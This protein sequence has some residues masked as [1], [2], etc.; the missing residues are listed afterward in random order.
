MKIERIKKDGG[1][2]GTCTQ[3]GDMNFEEV[4]QFVYLGELI[5]SKCEEEKEI[6]A[7]LSKAN[8]IDESMSHPLGTKQLSRTTKFRLYE[9]VIRPSELY[10]RETLVL[11][12]TTKEMLRRWER[13]LLRRILCGKTRKMEKK[14]KRRDLRVLSKTTDRLDDK[15]KK[16]AVVGSRREKGRK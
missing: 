5:T 4:D 11:N 16:V 13:K 1:E 7:R 12:Q 2:F 10:G 15:S 6:D 3:L 14:N 9:T 8:R